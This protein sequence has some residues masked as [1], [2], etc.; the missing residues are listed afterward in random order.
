[1]TTGRKT[2]SLS[3]FLE[4]PS[5]TSHTSV[6]SALDK[7]PKELCQDPSKEHY[8][9]ESQNDKGERDCENGLYQ[10]AQKNSRPPQL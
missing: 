4:T 7:E 3:R 9:Y 2:S 6:L 1:M 8:L 10:P 5:Q